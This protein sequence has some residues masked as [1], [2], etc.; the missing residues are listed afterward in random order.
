MT[1]DALSTLTD[2]QVSALLQTLAST[3][4]DFQQH[5]KTLTAALQ[6]R[7]L[8]VNEQLDLARESLRVLAEAPACA[9]RLAVLQNNAGHK[10]MV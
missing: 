7:P 6:N 10:A 1:N 9:H 8:P 2:A 5:T 3:D 4:P